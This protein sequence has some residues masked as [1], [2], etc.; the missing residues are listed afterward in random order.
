MTHYSP[1]QTEELEQLKDYG[2]DL[3]VVKLAEEE[4]LVIE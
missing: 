3:P 1:E 4:Y 2:E